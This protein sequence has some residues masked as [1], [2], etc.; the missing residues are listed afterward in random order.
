M[1]KIAREEESCT[2]PETTGNNVVSCSFCLKTLV[3]CFGLHNLSFLCKHVLVRTVR[4]LSQFM[5]FLFLL[6]VK[7]TFIFVKLYPYDFVPPCIVNEHT[8]Q[9]NAPKRVPVSTIVIQ[10]E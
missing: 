3:F 8:T 4:D 5:C 6:Y 2:G 9:Y 10:L 7:L 1:R